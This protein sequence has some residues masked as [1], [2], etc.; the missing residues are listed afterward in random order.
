MHEGG[1]DETACRDAVLRDRL[2]PSA[3]RRAVRMIARSGADRNGWI[4]L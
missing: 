4:A 2:A 1:N 3:E